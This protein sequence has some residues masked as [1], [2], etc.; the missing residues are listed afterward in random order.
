MYVVACMGTDLTAGLLER[1]CNS[2]CTGL[3]HTEYRMR[4]Q[5]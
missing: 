3:L 1:M 2:K 5:E 4:I